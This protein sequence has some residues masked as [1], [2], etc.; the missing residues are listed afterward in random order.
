MGRFFLYLLQYECNELLRGVAVP[1]IPWL[2]RTTGDNFQGVPGIVGYVD[3]GPGTFEGVLV[4]GRWILEVFNSNA[5]DQMRV[6]WGIFRWG[7]VEKGL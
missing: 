5:G 1:A 2:F 3:S 4:G 6:C 7:C